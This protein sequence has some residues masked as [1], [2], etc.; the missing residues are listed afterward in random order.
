MG[1][2]D[3]EGKAFRLALY[4]GFTS[5]LFFCDDGEKLFYLITVEKIGPNFL[6]GYKIKTVKVIL[7]VSFMA[8]VDIPLIFTLGSV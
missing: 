7:D 8:G 4:P 6:Y 3:Q 1:I 5:Q 2:Y